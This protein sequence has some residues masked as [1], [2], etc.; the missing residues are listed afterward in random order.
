[1]MYRDWSLLVIASLI[2]GG[3]PRI[4][5]D[6]DTLMALVVLTS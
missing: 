4:N 3:A 2:I 1:M 6:F 5:S